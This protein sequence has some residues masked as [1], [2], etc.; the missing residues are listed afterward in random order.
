MH[1]WLN[2]LEISGPFLAVPVLRELFP[3][4]LE[5]LDT[6]RAKRLRSAY[7]EWRDAVDDEDADVERLH[8]AWIDEVLRTALEVDDTVLRSGKVVPASS[9]HSTCSVEPSS[10]TLVTGAGMT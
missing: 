5:E 1:E 9:V 6:W 8:V 4:G 3:Q 10:G 7:E 2:L